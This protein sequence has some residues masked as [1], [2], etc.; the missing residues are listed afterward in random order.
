MTKQIKHLLIAFMAIFL[1]AGC[2]PQEKADQKNEPKTEQEAKVIHA[3]VNV[4]KDNAKEKILSTQ[5]EFKEGDNLLEAMKTSIPVTDKKGYV[6]HISGVEAKEKDK[7]AWFLTVNGEEAQTGA[8]EII[9][10]D[11]DLVNWDLHSWE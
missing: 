10:K 1:V 7:M 2:A 5:I 4:T 6:T 8:S 9:L 3:T 11:G